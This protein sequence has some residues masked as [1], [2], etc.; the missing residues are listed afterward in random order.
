MA[1]ISSAGI[2]SGLDVEGLISRLVAVER[3]P[4]NQLKQRTDGLKT[5]LSAFGRLQSQLSAVKDA[6]V[7]LNRAD[8][9][10]GVTGATSDAT[11]A[12]AT[13]ASGA[14]AGSY[15]VNVS[16]LAKVQSLASDPVPTNSSTGTGTLTITFGQFSN[17]LTGFAADPSRTALVIPIITGADQLEKVRDQINA[18]KA[19]VVASVV[20]DVN[21][22]RLV[23]R[24]TQSGQANGFKVEVADDDGNPTDNAGLSRFAYDPSAVPAPINPGL[25]KQTAGNAEVN[26]NGID[27][28]SATNQVAGAVEGVTFNLLKAQSTAT[29]TV[30]Q[31]K[32]GIK[33]AVTD[34][35]NAYNEA[36][37]LVREQIRTD[38][39]TRTGGPLRGDSTVVGIQAQLR[40]LAGSSTTLGGSIGRLADLGLDPGADGTLKIDAAKLDKAL[41]DKLP[42]VRAFF[43]GVDSGNAGNNGISQRFKTLLDGF[44]DTDGR[45]EN[46]KSGLQSRITQN[47]KRNDELERR[48]ELTEK[49]LRAQYTALD[50]TMSRATSLSTYLQNQLQRL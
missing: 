5:Q 38:P 37:K 30:S 18:L 14:A 20:T 7:R 36:I 11:V 13:T 26:I 43:S 41:T 28:V 34:F 27:I 22:S 35:A 32:E 8:T 4:I 24:G 17:D 50:G 42:E 6:A 10:T 15:T 23:M 29:V 2:G 33:K 16:K 25:S 19:G 45:L 47:D 49:R 21:G 3:T 46:R 48:V 44:L 9:Y 39:A 1:S 12:T 31:D 40:S